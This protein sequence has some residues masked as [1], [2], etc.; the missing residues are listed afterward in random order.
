MIRIA[1][2][3]N[4]PAD[5]K[6]GASTRVQGQ[7]H[8]DLVGDTMHGLG[9]R[10]RVG[11]VVDIAGA[12]QGGNHEAPRKALCRTRAIAVDPVEVG[13]QSVDHRVADEVDLL[14]M[15]AFVAQVGDG[16]GAGRKQEVGQPVRD[17][18]VDL[19]G[20]RHVEAAQPGFDVGDQ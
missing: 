6:P 4:R 12:V 7:H 2:W 18:P 9:Q 19:L 3:S 14:R 17:Q 15:D 5:S 8:L 11:R 16:V 1:G 10:L 13:Q 20:H